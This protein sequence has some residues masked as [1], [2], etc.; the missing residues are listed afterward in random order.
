MNTYTHKSEQILINMY[1]NYTIIKVIE[2]I[3]V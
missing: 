1:V 2:N 3:S